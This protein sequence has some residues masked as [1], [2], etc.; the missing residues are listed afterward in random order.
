MLSALQ[1]EEAHTDKRELS[2]LSQQRADFCP[3]LVFGS[4]R[5]TMRFIRGFADLPLT[6]VATHSLL[7]GS[8]AQFNCGSRMERLGA[9]GA[10][11]GTGAHL[12]MGRHSLVDRR[13]KAKRL[14]LGE[15]G[16]MRHWS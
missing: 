6:L 7:G 13:D 4:S 8:A 12:W 16:H 5:T 1:C 9:R 15:Q 10:T 11:A 2:L 3:E 14:V